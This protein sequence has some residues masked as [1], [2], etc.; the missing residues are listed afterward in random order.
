MGD[1]VCGRSWQP[2]DLRNT[3][4][5]RDDDR[6][7]HLRA[8]QMRAMYQV[9]GFRLGSSSAHPEHFYERL[10]ASSTE[11]SGKSIRAFGFSSSLVLLP[12]FPYAR[13]AFML[14]SGTCSLL[15]PLSLS[16]HYIGA[17]TREGHLHHRHNPYHRHHPD[18]WLADGRTYWS[19]HSL[20]GSAVG[21]WSDGCNF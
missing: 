1:A 3:R 19:G 10:V 7:H 18:P 15:N 21:L 12:Q 5:E 13:L 17:Y 2:V 16:L 9:S 20:D 8:I 4:D 14:I 6:N 11:H